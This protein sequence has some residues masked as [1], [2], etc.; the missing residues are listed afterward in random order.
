MTKQ[1]VK[2]V[3]QSCVNK[4]INRQKE[5]HFSTDCHE[6]VLTES[7]GEISE[8]EKEEAVSSDFNIN[9]NQHNT[10]LIHYQEIFIL[11][12]ISLERQKK[13]LNTSLLINCGVHG[14]KHF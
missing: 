5:L 10:T 1:V 13:A 3:F 4:V 7:K 12:H 6:A 2:L 11:A 14:L 8:I 9:Q